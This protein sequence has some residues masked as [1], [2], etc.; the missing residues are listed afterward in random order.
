MI[1]DKVFEDAAF[2]QKAGVIGPVL[3]TQFGYVLIQVQQHKP[4]S[5]IKL[6]DVKERVRA[7]ITEQNRKKAVQ[8]YV[9][10]LRAKAK[11]VYVPAK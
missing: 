2:T 4:P 6:D 10:A 7:L 5:L 1:Q 3:E 8:D 9:A 11:V